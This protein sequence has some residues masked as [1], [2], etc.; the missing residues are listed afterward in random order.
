[1]CTQDLLAVCTCVKSSFPMA[2]EAGGVS[3]SSEYL[4]SGVSLD[5]WKISFALLVALLELEQN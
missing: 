3:P 5:M 1:M 4:L 2:L